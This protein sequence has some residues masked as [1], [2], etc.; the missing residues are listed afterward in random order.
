MKKLVLFLFAIA[1]L[2]SCSTFSTVKYSETLS[3][4]LYNMYL[5]EGFYIYPKE[6]SHNTPEYIPLSYLEF[7]VR[8]GK[9]EKGQDTTGLIIIK[10]GDPNTFADYAY[11]SYEYLVDKLVDAA[12][13][14]GANAIV[15]FSCVTNR[16]SG[17]A[18]KLIKKPGNE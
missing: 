13:N 6:C 7:K 12:K 16:A 9:P 2:A 18:V 10:E 5:D 1:A 17:I 8:P 3:G 14:L 11:P 15:D 4:Q